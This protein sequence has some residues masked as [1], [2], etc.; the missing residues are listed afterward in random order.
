M[1]KTGVGQ[2]KV[3]F[4]CKVYEALTV[5]VDLVAFGEMAEYA[6]VEFWDITGLGISVKG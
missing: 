6:G 4:C 5:C 3:I 2:E 1:L